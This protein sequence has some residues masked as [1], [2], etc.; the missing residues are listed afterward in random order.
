MKKL[1]IGCLLCSSFLA[2][3]TITQADT[4]NENTKTEISVTFV[5]PI[6][7]NNL[8]GVTQSPNNLSTKPVPIISTQ[9]PKTNEETYWF[10][11][12]LGVLLMLCS[13]GLYIYKKKEVDN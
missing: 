12:L 1:V 5:R 13:I 8:P 11:S 3:S 7:S 6:T 2:G 9:L 4:F 10:D